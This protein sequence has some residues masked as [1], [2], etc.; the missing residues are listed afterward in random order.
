MKILI[1][2][3]GDLAS[4]IAF[5]LF[6]AGYTI[7]MTDLPV[8]TAVRRTVSFSSAVYQNSIEIEHVTA[9][10]AKDF[11]SAMQIENN[12]EIPVFADPQAKVA[13]IWKPEVM[14]DAIMAKRNIGTTKEDAK[15]VIGIGPGFCAGTDCHCVIETKRGHYL[16]KVL[17]SGCAIANTGIPGE[18]GGFTI[19]RLIRAGADGI[20]KPVAQ[21]GEFVLKDTVVAYVADVP[22]YAQISGVV[23]GLLQEGVVVYKGMK[24]GDID[25]R[26][27][28]EHCNTISD[29]ARSIGGGALEAVCAYEHRR[30]AQ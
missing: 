10:Y 12:G 21:I 13:H 23:R 8:P 15:L 18:V 16:G 2:G 29:K 4:G 5:R 3:A 30:F 6:R 22:V 25:A 17:E 11:D 26:C 9:R 24:A 1:K 20:F 27:E 19:E 7:W 14:I 28:K